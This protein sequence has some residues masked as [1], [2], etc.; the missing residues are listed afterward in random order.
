MRYQAALRSEP[1]PPLAGPR[2]RRNA[3]VSAPAL[4]V[5]WAQAPTQGFQ[6]RQHFLQKHAQ[7]SVFLPKRLQR[8][9]STAAAT[10]N[11]ACACRT[12]RR[13]SPPER[14]AGHGKLRLGDFLRLLGGSGPLFRRGLRNIIG[15]AAAALAQQTLHAFDGIALNIKQ[16]RDASEKNDIVR[17]IIAPP[18]AAFQRLDLRELGLPKP[19]NVLGNMQFIGHLADGAEGLGRFAKLVVR[20]GFFPLFCRLGFSRFGKRRIVSVHSLS[21]AVSTSLLTLAFNTWLG[22][23]TNTRRGNMGTSTPVLGLRP[24]RRPFWRTENVPKPLILTES[25][26]SKAWAM[27]SRIISKSAAD[28]LRES[29]TSR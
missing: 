8:R 22:R 28:S 9:L 6:L 12:A 13:R 1:S 14:Q 2:Q 17:A 23:N 25:P 7:L 5:L 29:P 26:L 21:P 15:Q 20:A 27:R 19:Q 4:P 24:T 10:A 3:P 16:I 11:A 18:A